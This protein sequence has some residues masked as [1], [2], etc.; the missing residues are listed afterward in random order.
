MLKLSQL[1]WKC[2]K[3]NMRVR[4]GSQKNYWDNRKRAS[5]TSSGSPN[6]SF[7]PVTHTYNSGSGTETVPTGATSLTITS[8]SGGG[9]G[10]RRSALNQA[11]GGG[12]AESKH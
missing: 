7:T 3:T 1:R 10:S 11:G 5:E 2:S 4:A 12:G 8:W 9:G 6:V